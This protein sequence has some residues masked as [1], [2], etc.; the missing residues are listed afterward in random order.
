[1][2][3]PLVSCQRSAEPLRPDLLFLPCRSQSPFANS[4]NRC[5]AQLCVASHPIPQGPW[6]IPSLR[7]PAPL[8]PPP[9]SALPSRHFLELSPRW[10]RPLPLQ[11]GLQHP[12]SPHSAAYSL[13][14]RSPPQ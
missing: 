13:P 9:F 2:P 1:M 6:P 8:G 10:H 14:S 11:R 3:L 5:P 4:R 12:P 7:A